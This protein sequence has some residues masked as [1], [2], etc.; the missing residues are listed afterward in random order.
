M[1]L[2]ISPCLVAR[3]AQRTGKALDSTCLRYPSR[4]NLG[5]GTDPATSRNLADLFNRRHVGDRMT[6]GRDLTAKLLKKQRAE[7]LL[8]RHELKRRI[9]RPGPRNVVWGMD[10]TGK[11]DEDGT[12]HF[13]LGIVDHGSR[14]CVTLD[15]LADKRSVTVVRALCDAVERHG[16]PKAIRTDNEAIFQSRLFKTA[17][18]LLDIRHQTTELH[19]PWQ[20]GR[21]ERFFGTLKNKLDRWAVAD[22]IALNTSLV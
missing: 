1:S 4:I 8:R 13:L 22:G 18:G 12:L 7:I 19:C 9:Y 20:N 2:P 15:A 10:G 14:H 21:I 5:S 6:V 3:G 11:A 16:K 17:L